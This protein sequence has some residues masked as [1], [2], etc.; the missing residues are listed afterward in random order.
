MAILVLAFDTTLVEQMLPSGMLSW[1]NVLLVVG[2]LTYEYHALRPTPFPTTIHREH[3]CTG[4][5]CKVQ[6][7]RKLKGAQAQPLGFLEVKI[8]SLNEVGWIM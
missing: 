8:W 6:R 1:Y 5:D 2:D 4:D 3:S 7:R